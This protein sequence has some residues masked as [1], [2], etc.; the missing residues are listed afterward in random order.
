MLLSRIRCATLVGVGLVASAGTRL[1]DVIRRLANDGKTIVDHRE[2]IPDI[3]SRQGAAYSVGVAGDDGLRH[4]N[5]R[6]Y[7]SARV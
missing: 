5:L 4:R 7:E 1:L 3:R 6:N 2:H